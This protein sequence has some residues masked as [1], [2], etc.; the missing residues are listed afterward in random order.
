M[1]LPLTKEWAGFRKKEFYEKDLKMKKIDINKI[2]T[3][4]KSMRRR[5]EV[6][7]YGE[8]EQEV[9]DWIKENDFHSFQSGQYTNIVIPPETDLSEIFLEA[10]QF[11]WLDGFSPNLNKKLHIG[12]FS[13]MV[14]A[15]AFKSLG[16][17]KKTVSIYG[18]TIDGE[19]EK[20][21]ALS[22]L[23]KYQKDFDFFINK[24][25]MASEVTYNN[26]LLKD[27]SGEYEGTK[28]FEIGD[29]KI[30]GIK[31]GGQT[32]YF[33]QDVA[34][35][36][37]LN[38]PT[39]YLT[40]NEQQNHFALLKKIYPHIQHVG[41]GLVKVSGKKMSSRMGNV[42][43]MEEFIDLM[44]EEFDEDLK[45]IYNVF[46][47]HIL[48][49]NPEVD[50]GINLDIINN[51]KNSSGLYMSYTMARL[52]SA[53]CAVSDGGNGELKSIELNFAYLKA[54]ANL[55][56]N[57]LYEEL[58]EHCKHINACYAIFTIKENS[59][60]IIM[61]EGLLDDLVWGCKKLGMFVIT[62]V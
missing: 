11:E 50:K 45:L 3:V 30:V 31:S 42:I 46:A 58:F 55:K 18:D 37:Q 27:G 5:F 20:S 32:S 41:L 2:K 61:F 22:L 10:K 35:A 60:N 17:C 9:K 21:E 51:P 57:I 1:T 52:I 8:V 44:K 48:K 36:E 39:L 40:G 25:V 14:L 59:E 15:K 26:T 23:E 54:R 56:P 49:S 19:I 29:E 38:S 16:I 28:I 33:Y 6:C 12:H 53:G 43:L 34:L 24:E 7:V 47:G 4:P 13:N 62:K